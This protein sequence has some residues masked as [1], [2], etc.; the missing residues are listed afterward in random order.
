MGRARALPQRL[1]PLRRHEHARMDAHQLGLERNR[2]REQ[3]VERRHV[4]TAARRGRV[5]A[6]PAHVS[7]STCSTATD[8]LTMRAPAAVR[9]VREREQH[10]RPAGASTP[11]TTNTGVYEKSTTRAVFQL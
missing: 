3:R 5:C 7:V 6:T 2:M 9:R 1:E 10:E 4:L 11:A 8:V